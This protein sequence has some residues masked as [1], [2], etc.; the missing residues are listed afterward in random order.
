MDT[1][2]KIKREDLEELLCLYHQ[3]YEEEDA[4]VTEERKQAFETILHRDDQFLLVTE[5]KGKIIATVHLTIL[6]NL[7]HNG[8]SAA[9]I[10]NVIVD[11][12][13]RGQKIGEAIM[14][15]AI[16]IAEE[17]RCY[18]VLLCTGTISHEDP[19]EIMERRHRFYEKVGLRRGIKNALVRYFNQ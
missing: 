14:T 12:D 10:E 8:A 16:E 4:V 18:R 2:R 5:R 11:K 9:Y 1:I 3:L 19:P 7:S 17:Y 6:P 15:R 13:H